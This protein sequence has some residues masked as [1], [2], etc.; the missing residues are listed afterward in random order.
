MEASYPDEKHQSADRRFLL[1]WVLASVIGWM[2]G[3]R[4]G[5]WI[6]SQFWG[7]SAPPVGVDPTSMIVYLVALLMIGIMQW[8][9]LRSEISGS[10][11][12]II[13][14]AG[15]VLAGCVIDLIVTYGW[16]TP[17]MQRI[18]SRADATNPAAQAGLIFLWRI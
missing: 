9:A 16:F 18:E 8:L 7:L 2:V 15:G 1:N 12:W 14:T 5:A 6:A 17:V 3:I 13:A 4:V 10:W 11:R